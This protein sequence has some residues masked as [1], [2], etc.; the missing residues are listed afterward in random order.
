VGDIEVRSQVLFEQDTL[1]PGG[2]P[3]AAQDPRDLVDVALGDIGDREV[4][5]GGFGVPPR[6][7]DLRALVLLPLPVLGR[8]RP[9]KATRPDS[10]AGPPAGCLP[11]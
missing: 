7:R 5:L 10:T 2:D 1:A 8:L 9:G 6:S 11:S 4:D 3:A